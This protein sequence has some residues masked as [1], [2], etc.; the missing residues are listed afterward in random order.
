[1]SQIISLKTI[2]DIDFAHSLF[3]L[4]LG[5]Q[6]GAIT[7]KACSSVRADL[8]IEFFYFESILFSD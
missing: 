1:M 8:E 7:N 5:K 2:A 6:Y 4:N 3:T